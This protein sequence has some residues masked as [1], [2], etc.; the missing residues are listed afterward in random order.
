MHEQLDH[1]I[2]E[3]GSTRLA[4][5]A[6]LTFTPQASAVDPFYIVED[7]LNSRFFRLGHEEYTF[8][9]SLD[10]RTSIQDA[11][12]RLSNALPHHRLTE[13]DVAG[14]CRWLVE[15]DLAHTDES[16]QA[17]RLANAKNETQQRKR[18][19]SCNPL[20]FRVPLF[21]PD[22]L[23]AAIAP[24]VGW[25]FSPVVMVGW[26]A[27]V[28]FAAYRVF[29]DWD[30][31]AASSHGVFAPGN[32]LWL[33][34][35]WVI[36]K[37]VHETGHGLVCRRYGGTVRE[38]GITFILLMPLAYVDVT[39]S[40]RFRSRL[41]RIHVAAAGMYIELL[42]AALAVVVWSSV[43]AGWL[44]NLC[45]N[46]ILMA[47]VT[48][49]LFNA[50]PLMKFDGYFILSD[51]LGMPNLYVNG[52]QY[53]RYWARRY[54]LGVPAT[55]PDWSPRH[56]TI[57]RIYGVASFF[58]RV[59]ICV[60]LTVAAAALFHGAGIV[61]ACL[62]VVMWLGLPTLKFCKYLICGKLGEQPRRLR[63]FLIAGTATASCILL[64]GF[65]PWPGAR[66]APAVVEY[67]P[68]TVVRSDSA[69]FISEIH[70]AS[71]QL[72]DRGQLLVTLENREL[73]NKLADLALQIRQSE[74]RGHQHEQKGELAAEQAEAKQR[75]SL[76]TQRAEIRTQ[77]EQLTVRA[78]HSGKVIRRDL[79]TLLGT[80]LETGDEIVSIGDESKK[81]LRISVSQDDVD[82][83]R[84]RTGK[85]VRIDLPRH[86]LRQSTLE[87]VIPRATPSVPHPA[88]AAVNGGSLPVK[89][90][91]D[92]DTDYELFSPRFTGI[93]QLE[94]SE[95]Q[96]LRTG[97]T[98]TVSYR[99][100]HESIGEHLYRSFSD[101]LDERLNRPRP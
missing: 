9:S 4:L 59:L 82:V 22:R 66:Q 7:P 37:I 58:W 90:A 67:S 38:T 99:A 97:Q 5:R 63:F 35:C 13:H 23:F 72:V 62:A 43:E 76:E 36:L 47:S 57:I 91:A 100:L 81:E 24:W 2:R 42:L 19:A 51:A 85:Q 95:S 17:T 52:Q 30:R 44:S 48:T 54:L 20:M 65:V 69:G 25:L 41:Q 61:L 21:R 84:N 56:G 87:K 60:S 12:S 86:S 93:V 46:V 98:G 27:L 68:H 39:S 26:L 10:G 34:V 50:N 14:L 32:W 45:F 71:D 83:F 33:G 92:S 88:L 55:L 1:S 78:P 77:V 101:W 80:Y 18:L 49:L 8:I 74:I 31:F 3:F 16:S 40:W 28:G 6:D 11:L 73:T 15:M 53:L 79:A 70:V 96:H 75:E 29:S 94:D 64:F 89:N